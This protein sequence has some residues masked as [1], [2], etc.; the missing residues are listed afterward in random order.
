MS[1][2][3]GFVIEQGPAVRSV[4]PTWIYTAGTAIQPGN[5][6]VIQVRVSDR[7]GNTVTKSLHHAISLS[8]T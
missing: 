7:P 5:T 4:N 6:V 3:D 2:L 8:N 1:T